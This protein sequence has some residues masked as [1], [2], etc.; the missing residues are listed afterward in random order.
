MDPQEFLLFADILQNK[1]ICSPECDARVGIDRA[2]YAAAHV[3]WNTILSVVNNRDTSNAVSDLKSI[4]KRIHTVIELV[5]RHVR[6]SDK[7]RMK[8]LYKKRIKSTY[9]LGT[10]INATQLMDA[11]TISKNII[12]GVAQLES[13][14]ERAYQMGR[15]NERYWSRLRGRLGK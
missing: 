11:V 1:G 14:M 8:S 10:S 5:L 4:S 15:L 9:R 12:S 3:T 6:A 7:N 13:E 2:Y